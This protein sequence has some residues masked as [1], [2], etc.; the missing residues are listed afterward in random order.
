MIQV[1]VEEIETVACWKKAAGCVCRPVASTADSMLDI[2]IDDALMSPIVLRLARIVNKMI[3][4]NL[5]LE[6]VAHPAP[7]RF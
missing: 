6:R 3:K 4:S 7:E 5:K 1:L 2:L